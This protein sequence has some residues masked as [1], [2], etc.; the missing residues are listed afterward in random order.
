MDIWGSTSNLQVYKS[1][2]GT[3]AVVP[4]SGYYCECPPFIDWQNACHDCY[5]D[6]KRS[7]TF[8]GMNFWSGCRYNSSIN[9]Y[10]RINSVTY[11]SVWDVYY[12]TSPTNGWGA[13]SGSIQFDAYTG[14]NCTG[15]VTSYTCAFFARLRAFAAVGGAG[16][17]WD[18]HVTITQA[19]FTYPNVFTHDSY[20]LHQDS[21]FCNFG[22]PTSG[23]VNDS[24]NIF[25]PQGA[26]ATVS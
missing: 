18:V 21:T 25:I 4:P 9:R 20:P 10:V 15:S 3:P 2:T 22:F 5:I 23:A 13:T 11:P 6:H 14:A 16:I 12:Q 7:I 19:G 26:V 1:K 17:D 24:N 8:S